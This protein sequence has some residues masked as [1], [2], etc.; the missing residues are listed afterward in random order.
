MEEQSAAHY[1]PLVS[2][3]MSMPNFTRPVWQDQKVPC[4]QCRFCDQDIDAYPCDRC[5]TRH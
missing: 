4:E 1:K 2:E 5:H 3:K